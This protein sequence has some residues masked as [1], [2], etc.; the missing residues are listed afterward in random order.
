MI[1]QIHDQLLNFVSIVGILYLQQKLSQAWKDLP[2][3]LLWETL[4]PN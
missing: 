2:N 3:K 4:F 1:R